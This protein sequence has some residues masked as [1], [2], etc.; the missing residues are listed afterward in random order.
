LTQAPCGGA[1]GP[2]LKTDIRI[3]ATIAWKTP[4]HIGQQPKPVPEALSTKMA[5]NGSTRWMAD[6][7][8]FR[9]QNT[10]VLL[11]LG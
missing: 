11:L 3:P 6:F 1:E 5:Q 4:M 10:Y 7:R 2:G 9:L 8:I